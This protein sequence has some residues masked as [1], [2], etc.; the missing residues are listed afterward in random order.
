MSAARTFPKRGKRAREQWNNEREFDDK[1][2]LWRMRDRA[3]AR[4]DAALSWR[5]AR[6]DGCSL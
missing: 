4:I 2:R 3:L 5:D 6:K 1:M